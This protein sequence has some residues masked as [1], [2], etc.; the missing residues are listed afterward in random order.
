MDNAVPT[1]YNVKWKNISFWLIATLVAGLISINSQS[2]WIDESVSARISSFASLKEVWRDLVDANA[3]DIQKPLY[4]LYSW[5]WEKSFGHSEILLR[6]SNIPLLFIGGW[7]FRNSP[8]KLLLFLSSPLIVYYTGEFRA[9]LFLATVSVWVAHQ[10]FIKRDENGNI[11]IHGFFASTLLLCSISM[12]GVVWA[13]GAFLAFLLIIKDQFKKTVFWKAT[14]TWSIPFLLLASYYFCILINGSNPTVI[15][16]SIIVNILQSAYEIAGFTGMGPG[17]Y[18][19]RE[20]MVSA[21]PW[22]P[23]LLFFGVVIGTAFMFSFRKWIKDANKNTIFAFFIAVVTPFILLSIMSLSRD[24]RFSGRHCT[25]LFGYYIIILTY[26]FNP[27]VRLWSRSKKILYSGTLLLFIISSLNVRF[28]QRFERENYKLAVEYTNS[29]LS[30]G[31]NIIWIAIRDGADWYGLN[32]K[33]LYNNNDNWANAQE[34]IYSRPDLFPREKAII[35]QLLKSG[36]YTES[37][38]CQGF[39]L[40]KKIDSYSV[41]K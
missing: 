29:Q 7:F 19:A 12:I 14:L 30:A 25:P 11:S 1:N 10:L 33:A 4:V 22:I 13:I 36:N 21:L 5:C 16:S 38:F 8:L 32:P 31:K 27:P 35:D 40:I 3:S 15:P 20:N 23:S 24:F 2:F 9:Y 18:E 28:H 41:P 6:A 37:Y 17:R 34:I 39:K 26:C